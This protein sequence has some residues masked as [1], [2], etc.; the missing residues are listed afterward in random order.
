VY[1]KK[2]SLYAGSSERF[3]FFDF[4]SYSPVFSAYGEELCAR[5]FSYPLDMHTRENISMK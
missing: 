2:S 3:V 5:E 1:L 4:T